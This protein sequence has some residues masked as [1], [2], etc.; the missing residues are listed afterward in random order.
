MDLQYEQIEDPILETL[1]GLNFATLDTY[2]GEFSPESFGQFHIPFP[3][4]YVHVQ[5]FDNSPVNYTDERDCLVVVYVASRDLRGDKAAKRGETGAYQLAYSVRQQLNRLRIDSVGR[6][7]LARE[8]IVGYSR[9][10]NV[11]VM[12]CEYKVK[13]KVNLK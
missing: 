9:S 13:H 7:E 4:A 8:R 12:R 2:G 11:C 1:Q 10:L 3:A 6:L 5:G